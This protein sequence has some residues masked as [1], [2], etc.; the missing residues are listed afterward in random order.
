[1]MFAMSST[2]RHA[3]RISAA[4]RRG[5]RAALLSGSRAPLDSSVRPGV[6]CAREPR[7]EHGGV[8]SSRAREDSCGLCAFGATSCYRRV[9]TDH[10]RRLRGA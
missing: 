5:R 6:R 10:M 3:A 4:H 1:M 2:S 9:A 7:G 8:A